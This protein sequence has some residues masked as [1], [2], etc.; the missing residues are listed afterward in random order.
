[1]KSRGFY[2]PE[3]DHP[4]RTAAAI[5]LG[6]VHNTEVGFLSCSCGIEALR[7][8]PPSARKMFFGACG[9]WGGAGFLSGFVGGGL[10]DAVGWGG[11]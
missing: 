8:R 3:L 4:Q 6:I 9:Y 7:L 5:V 1:M 2:C 10:G 11:R